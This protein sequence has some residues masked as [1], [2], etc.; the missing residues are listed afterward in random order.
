M[1]LF[2]CTVKYKVEQRCNSVDEWL[3]L[4]SSKCLSLFLHQ[5]YT[6][7][8][9]PLHIIDDP[10]LGQLI[11]SLPPLR[12]CELLDPA[13]DQT[14]PR[15]IEVLERRHRIRQTITEQVNRNGTGQSLASI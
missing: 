10:V 15:L 9:P 8:F 14:L 2:I 5:I 11:E 4:Q 1:D 3:V 12:P 6:I 7:F 13:D